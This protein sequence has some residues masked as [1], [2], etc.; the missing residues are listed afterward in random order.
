MTYLSAKYPKPEYS[1][2]EHPQKLCEYISKHYFTKSGTRIL[3]VG[4]G[5]GN[6]LV[7]FQR[8]GFRVYGIDRYIATPRLDLPIRECDIEGNPLPYGNGTFDYVFCKSVIEHVRDTD[9]LLR[10]ILRVLKPEGTAVIMTPDWVS[11]RKNFWDDHT[12]VS[13]FTRKGLQD[14]ML[15]AGFR[16]VR[17]SLFWQLPFVWEHPFWGFVPKLISLLPDSLKWKD[18]EQHEQRKLVRFSKEKMLLGVGDK[19]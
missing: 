17:V 6:H 14:A 19:P 5:Q 1:L 3:D 18:Y 10:E 4:C 15:I 12:H 11:Q 13:P 16:W 2:A 7:G 8:C 9:N